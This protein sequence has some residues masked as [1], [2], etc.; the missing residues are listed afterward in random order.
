MCWP[1]SH[2]RAFQSAPQSLHPVTSY[3]ALVLSWQVT[4]WS[5]WDK[6]NCWKSSASKSRRLHPIE[7]YFLLNAEPDAG[8]LSCDCPP[9]GRWHQRFVKGQA[10]KWLKAVPLVWTQARGYTYFLEKQEIRPP[11][12]S[13]GGGNTPLFLVQLL[14]SHP[15]PTHKVLFLK[16]LITASLL[17][18]FVC[19]FDQCHI[20]CSAPWG[21][22]HPFDGKLV[23]C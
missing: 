14:P 5:S 11:V 3:H 19:F 7:A 13:G 23:A 20:L 6:T 4:F 1:S 17:H 22:G 8:V 16:A 21:Q 12:C 2:V 10:Q 18:A 15:H 9:H